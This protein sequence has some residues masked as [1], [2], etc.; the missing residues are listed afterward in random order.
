MIG[1]TSHA[2]TSAAATSPAQIDATRIWN[3]DSRP[4]PDLVVVPAAADRAPP[5]AR[6]GQHYAGDH[7]DDSYHPE[8]RYVEKESRGQKND[9]ENDQS[10]LLEEILTVSGRAGPRSSRDPTR[11]TPW[12]ISGRVHNWL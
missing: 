2:D 1:W 10:M 3:S 12:D 6:N 9:S 8:D 5:A 7:E 11:R 4:R